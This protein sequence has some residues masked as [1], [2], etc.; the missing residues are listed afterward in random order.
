METVKIKRKEPINPLL[1]RIVVWTALA[2]I[3][4]DMVY[5]NINGIHSMNREALCIVY[6]TLPRWLFLCWEN[7]IETSF[8]VLI[9]IFTGTIVENYS[10]K[11]KRFFPKNQLLAFLYGAIL[12]V[13]S[14]GAIPLIEVMKQRCSLRTVITFI[15]AAPL[16]NPFI[17]I[18]SFSLLGVQ[19]AIIRV[20]ASFV[21]AMGA[22]IMVE[23]ISKK[24]FKE[25]YGK[26]ESCNPS[27]GCTAF[28]QD[29]FVKTMLLMK[30]IMPYI[31]VGGLITLSLELFNPKQI[32][33]FFNF[34]NQWLSMLIMLV[35][36]IPIFVCNG[37][38]ML[39]MKPLLEF[40]DLTVGSSMVFSLTSS[41]VC[42]SSIVITAKFLGKKMTTLL[43]VCMG[44]IIFAIGA[45]INLL[46]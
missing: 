39:I 26:Y 18:M 5:A 22:G 19:Y 38:D 16:L 14:C 13:C 4:A 7:F 25:E 40:T 36:G 32:L 3:I 44:V 43:V 46:F 37:A 41:S 28:T 35:V 15:I 20:V 30:Q 31:L 33:Y 27:G 8:I 29:I 23:W 24:F 2:V 11:L 21:L 1:A 12:P 10:R 34:S 42:I 17:V 6:K 9:G 45:I